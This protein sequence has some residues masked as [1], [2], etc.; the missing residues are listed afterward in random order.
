MSIASCSIQEIPEG[1]YEPMEQGGRVQ[2]LRVPGYQEAEIY[3]PR[4]YDDSEARYPVL[5]LIHGGG[6]T[7]KSFL[8]K[9]E[10]GQADGVLLKNLLDH[11]IADG[12][13]PPLIVA[14]PT[15]YP[16]GWTNTGVAGSHTAVREFGPVLRSVILP[17]VDQTFR[18]VPDRAHRGISGFSMGGVTTWFAF[19]EAMDLFRWFMPLSGDCWV[20]AELGGSKYAQATAEVLAAR[21]RGQDFF[22]HAITGTEDIAYPNLNAQ[23]TAMEEYP[24]A[25]AFGQKTFY[26]LLTGGVHAYPDIRRYI[27]H[28][29][30]ELF[31]VS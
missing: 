4:G 2:A 28:A 1:Y 5:Y 31:R 17:L 24:E 19:L 8:A 21:A 16:D 11:M 10:D 30:P 7:P 13:M 22:L 14:A 15:F 27:F 20:H 6:N 26:S 9:P 12:R 3:L 23:M 25:F 18:T 29:L